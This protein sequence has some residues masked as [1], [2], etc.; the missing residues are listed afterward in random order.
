MKMNITKTMYFIKVLKNLRYAKLSIKQIAEECG[1]QP[2]ILYNVINRK[3]CNDD[4]YYYVLNSIEE[5][6]NEEYNI[7]NN[8]INRETNIS[9]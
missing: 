3:T 1:I 6:H 5:N 7:I 4:I 8:L 2:Y 9:K